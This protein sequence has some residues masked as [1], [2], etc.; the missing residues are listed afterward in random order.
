MEVVSGQ[1]F[2][3][4]VRT[5]ILRPLEMNDTDFF[6]PED[7]RDRFASCYMH[8]GLT[9]SFELTNSGH[10]VKHENR[11]LENEAEFFSDPEIASGGGGL[12]GTLRD[13]ANFCQMMLNKGTFKGRKLLSRK[14]VEFMGQNHAGGDL[15]SLGQKVFLNM[16]TEGLGF[17]LGF[18]VVT[19]PVKL[20][21]LCSEGEMAWGGMASTCFWIDPKEDLFVVMMTQLV[22]SSTYNFRRQIRTLVYQALE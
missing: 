2:A 4:F 20:Q 3:E 15:Y 17:G 22:P 5:K 21:Q 10:A 11:R 16:P 9:P 18:S 1:P 13:Y 14:T 8:V 7:K 6:V 12:V 19:D